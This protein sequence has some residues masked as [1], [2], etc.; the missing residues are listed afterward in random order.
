M[1][2]EIRCCCDGRLLGHYD[3]TEPALNSPVILGGLRFTY[4]NL[5]CGEKLIPALKSRDYL[6]SELRAIAGFKPATFDAQAIL[7]A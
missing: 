2:I 3:M 4:Q 7:D 5:K 6:D 1:N